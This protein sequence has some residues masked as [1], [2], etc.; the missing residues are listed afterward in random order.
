MLAAP[1][2]KVDDLRVSEEN[3][4]APPELGVDHEAERPRIIREIVFGWERL[5]LVY[6]LILLVPGVLVLVLW[7]S[8]HGMPFAAAVVSGVIVG[9]GANVAFLLGPLAELYFRGIFRNGESIG[10]GR[11][12]IFGAGLVISAGVFLLALIGGLVG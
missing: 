11:W 9:I 6:N 10:R 5:R 7:S 3:P 8:R 2:K 4:Y 1:S 12:L